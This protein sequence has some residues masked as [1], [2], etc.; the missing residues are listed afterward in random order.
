MIGSVLFLCHIPHIY[1]ILQNNL[2]RGVTLGV[3]KDTYIVEGIRF[4]HLLSLLEGDEKG[5][6]CKESWRRRRLRGCMLLPSK[7]L[8]KNEHIY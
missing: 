5:S 1:G 8:K 2:P 7:Y 3:A 6:P 4:F